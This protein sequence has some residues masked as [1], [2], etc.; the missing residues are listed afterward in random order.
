MVQIVQDNFTIK[1]NQSEQKH[2]SKL[3]P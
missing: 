1:Y 2:K 3:T